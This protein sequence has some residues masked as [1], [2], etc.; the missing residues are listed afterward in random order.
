MFMKS[1]KNL[2]RNCAEE[3][4]GS[5]FAEKNLGIKKK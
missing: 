5:G 2:D 1:E 4:S 3:F